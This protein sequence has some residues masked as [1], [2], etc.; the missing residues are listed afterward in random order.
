MGRLMKKKYNEFYFNDDEIIYPDSEYWDAYEN[1]KISAI[2]KYDGKMYCP[3]CLKAPLTIAN[4]IERKYFKVVNSDMGKHDEGCAYLLEKATKKEINQFYGEVDKDDIKNRLT[5]CM[6]KMLKKSIHN[7]EMNNMI[8]SLNKDSCSDMFVIENSKKEKKYL[9]NINLYSRSMKENI[10]IL[11]IYYGQCKIYV[12]SFSEKESKEVKR[13]YLNILNR[14]TLF[15]IC[16]VSLSPT[17]Y[18]YIGI[19]FSD[20]KENAKEYFLCFVAEMNLKNNYLNCSIGD[21]R[22]TLF[23]EI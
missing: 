9:P 11:K 10:S 2:K 19:N 14:N 7:T 12:T 13:Y 6:N 18:K 21:S 23:E 16:S 8:E 3:M 20:T 5:L 15:K 4:G 22:R 17:V 1:N